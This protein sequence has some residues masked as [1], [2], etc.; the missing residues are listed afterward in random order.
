M[1]TARKLNVVL[2][3]EESAGIQVLRALVQ[4]EHRV[5]AVMTSLPQTDSHASRVWGAAAKLGVETWPAKLVKDPSLASRLT[6]LGVDLILNVH[7]LYVIPEEVLRAA[8]IGTFN[9]HPGP[10]PRYAGLNVVS[11]AIYRGEAQHGVTVHKIEPEIDAGPIVFQAQF[12]IEENDTALSLGAKCT[13]NGV[14]LL[15]K[16]VEMAA[17]DSASISLVP[18]DLSRREYFGREVP[19]GG[20]IDW[21]DS[22]R[23]CVNFVRACDY[24]PFSSPWGHPRTL[25]DGREIGILKA[26]RTGKDCRAPPGTVGDLSPE[27]AC[28]ACADEWI[29]VKKLKVGS[30]FLSPSEVLRVGERLGG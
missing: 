1:T 5:V 17:K 30:K 22:A 15:L 24:F 8:S 3:A 14:P 16:L 25:V 2:I 28:I 6:A 20:W 4:S 10:L 29:L 18:Q 27:G 9:L 13:R 26:C 23:Q 21:S 12:P 11:W 19:R 7:S